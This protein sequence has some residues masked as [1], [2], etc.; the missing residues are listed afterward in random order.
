MGSG[1]SAGKRG[2]AGPARPNCP[3]PRL[4]EITAGI[5]QQSL[6]RGG[7]GNG[8]QLSHSL[9]QPS[10]SAARARV[11]HWGTMKMLHTLKTSWLIAA[12][13]VAV[14]VGEALGWQI[15]RAFDVRFPAVAVAALSVG[16]VAVVVSF[17]YDGSD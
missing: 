12:M 11:R 1:S 17:L 8:P 15:S 4:N 2:G 14:A 10:R 5:L 13:V 6:S 7:P 3:P 16:L 9:G